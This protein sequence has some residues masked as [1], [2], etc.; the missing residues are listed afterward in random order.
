LRGKRDPRRQ[1]KST[2]RIIRDAKSEEDGSKASGGCET[3]SRKVSSFPNVGKCTTCGK[4]ILHNPETVVYCDCYSKCTVCGEKLILLHRL[5]EETVKMLHE[6][7]GFDLAT[8]VGL[9]PNCSSMP[10]YTKGASRRLPQLVRLSHCS[11]PVR[12]DPKAFHRTGIP[13][14]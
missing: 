8:T 1:G 5:K 6:T 2:E 9:C 14:N 3:K 12:A 4:T 10:P 7:F 13:I 11:G